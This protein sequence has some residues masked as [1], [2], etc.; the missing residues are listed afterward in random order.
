MKKQSL[1]FWIASFLIFCLTFASHTAPGFAADKIKIGVLTPLTGWGADLGAAAK[2]GVNLALEEINASGGLL[3]QPV[4]VVF[5]DDETSPPKGIVA[6]REL[7]YAQKADVIIGPNFTTVNFAILPIINEAKIIHLT[8]GTGTSIINLERNPYTFRMHFYSRIE[9]QTIV[10]YAFEKKGYRKLAVLHDSSA[11]GKAG[12]A[13]LLPLLEKKG[14]TP[15]AVESYN[16]GDKNMTGQL[17]TIKRAGA[18]AILAWGLSPDMAVIAK[19]M[20]TLGMD[21]PVYGSAGLTSRYFKDLAGDVGGNF[22][23][24]MARNF[25]FNDKRPLPES[26]KR[27]MDAI[28]KRH[29]L[30]RQSSLPNS[31]SW[32]D[33]LH[34][35]AAAVRAASSTETEKVKTALESLRYPGLAGDV[36]FS[37]TDHEAQ[38]AR[39]LTLAYAAGFIPEGCFRRPE[40]ID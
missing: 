37:P 10:D 30:N 15:S 18:S 17:L 26:A 34:V 25:T 35:Y 33:G 2:E 39:Y 1:W 12:L 32:Y 3:G 23:G 16:I 40:D 9:A 31:A 29:G 14:I 11:Y 36:V 21:L 38:E 5:R 4:E 24:T 19:N 13:E 6:V 22:Y 27:Y 8:L 7:I 28:T 20:Q